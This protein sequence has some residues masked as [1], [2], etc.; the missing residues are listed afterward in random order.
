MSAG[1]VLS[2]TWF[3]PHQRTT[4]T[5]IQATSNYFGVAL[6][7]VLGPQMISNHN[8]AHHHSEIKTQI[9]HYMWVHTAFATV[10]LICTILYF[11]DRP[12]NA[13]S[14]SAE[15]ARVSFLSGIRQLLTNRQFW[16]VAFAYG[17]M[18]GMY[19]GWSSYLAPNLE[20]FLN[21]NSAED[22]S[23]WIGFYGTIAGC[24]GAIGFGVM[25]DVFVGRMKVG[26]QIQVDCTVKPTLSYR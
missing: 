26:M 17:I 21:N 2:A 8:M 13:P 18:T 3:P 9:L 23:G 16:I 20:T 25:A 14:T 4:A 12:P 24:V 5:S 7:F 19:S 10:I 22:E 1:P 6:S 11:P 15:K